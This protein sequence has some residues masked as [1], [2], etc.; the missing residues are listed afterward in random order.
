MQWINNMKIRT[1]LLAGFCMV[2]IIAT[3]IGM[4][5]VY[6]IRNINGNDAKLY[7]DMTVPISQLGQISTA[8]QRVRVNLAKVIL[9]E[10]AQ[11]RDEHKAQIKKLSEEIT[12]LTNS[13]DKGATSPE[14]KTL[15]KDFANARAV[16]IPIINRIVELSSSGK[17][18]DALA[19]YENE[20]VTAARHEQEILDKMVADKVKDAKETA[21][22]NAAE[23]RT[24]QILTI[25]F[26]LIGLLLAVTMGFSIAAVISAPLQKAVQFAAVV[27]SGDLS[28]ELNV[29][30]KDEI[31]MLADAL[32]DMTVRLRQVISKM[33]DTSGNL[34]SAANQLSS[35]SEQM[36]TGTEEVASQA[37][38]VAVASEEMSATSNDIAQNCHMAADSASRAAETTRKG[39][40]VV[41]STV[42]G[43]RYRGKRTKENAMIVASLGERS[44]QIGE[45]VSTIEDIADQTNLL[46]LNAAIEAARAGEQGRG[47]AV[48][49]DEVRALAERTTKATKEIS[50][51]I[52]AIQEETKTAIVSMEEGVRGTEKGASEAEQLEISLN[53]ILEQVS[54]VT[55]QIS[56]IA[57]AAE[58][59][60]STT[61]E[62]TSNIQ[63]ITEVVQETAR[64]AQESAGASGELARSA[65]DLQELASH[66]RMA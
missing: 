11:K 43:I 54:S 5:G 13:I 37:G 21:E 34:S 60:T 52:R 44:D 24:A 26:T 2:A 58:Q 7:R 19:I 51:M 48:V 18:A 66:F 23:G 14:E 55:M 29:R 33:I 53:E 47:F 63:Q 28:A 65:E 32:N 25:A 36:A 35:T 49:A 22:R 39:F 61:S 1:K 20:A 10:T 62:I 6:S 17:K 16:F 59:Q 12:T 27:A 9:E 45:I 40:E 15:L 4:V 3:V 50:G 57:T 31:G 8:F 30:R 46:A 41:K 38:T 42:E 64:G 56:Q